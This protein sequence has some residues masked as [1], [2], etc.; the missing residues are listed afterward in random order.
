VARLQGFTL[1]VEPTVF[2]PAFF[3][4]SRL[5][6]A[7][8]A[9]LDLAGRRVLDMGTGSGFLGLWAA[10]RGAEVVAL[11]AN[12]RAV[13]CARENAAT[14]GLADRMRVLE[15][16]LFRA[17]PAEAAFD[18]I[19][20][21][22]PFYPQD[23]EDA[24]ALAWKAGRDYSSLRAFA[25]DAGRFLARGGAV[26][27]VLSSDVDRPLICSLFTDLGFAWRRL[28]A[29]RGLFETLEVH[30]FRSTNA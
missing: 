23:P 6:A 26:V 4:S 24:G 30:E 28:R 25:A 7:H 9:S 11:D 20:W 1:R 22:P 18:L 16:D 3:R 27:L 2:H 8:V 13:A 29:S 19:L 21:N 12:P 14:N 15:S 5:L 10:R 17:L